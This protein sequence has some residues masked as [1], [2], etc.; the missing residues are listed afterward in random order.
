MTEI[1]RLRAQAADLAARIAR[2]EP[3]PEPEPA[4]EAR[5]RWTA[6]VRANANAKH[7]RT[8]PE[9]RAAF[10]AI[11]A[12]GPRVLTRAQIA[13]RTNAAKAAAH[14]AERLARISA[15]RSRAA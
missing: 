1:E 5:A 6:A 12:P 14:L 2:A 4:P 3:E 15:A 8:L 9:L 13:A 11:P 10:G 7:P